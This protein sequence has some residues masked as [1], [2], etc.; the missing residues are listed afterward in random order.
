MQ[1]TPAEVFL[2]GQTLAQVTV[3]KD[4]QLAYTVKVD[5][6]LLLGQHRLEVVQKTQQGERK[7]VAT[8]V[9]VRGEDRFDHQ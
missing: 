6:K 5:D 1:G 8:F 7:A 3:D 9:K 4:G 2:D